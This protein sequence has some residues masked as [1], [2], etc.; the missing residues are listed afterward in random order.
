M[1]GSLSRC[2]Y[3][4]LAIAAACVPLAGCQSAAA[5]H[6]QDETACAG[7]GFAPGTP[8]FA[9]CLQRETLARRGA[10]GFSLGLGFSGGFGR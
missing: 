5:L 9:A 2:A 6:K 4:A 1:S 7:Y 3:F 8:D 10:G